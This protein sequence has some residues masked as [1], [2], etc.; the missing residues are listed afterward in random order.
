[1]VQ[2]KRQQVSHLGRKGQ[3][4][5]KVV[6]AGLAVST[7]MS[8]AA[9]AEPLTLSANQMDKVTASGFGFVDFDVFFDKFKNVNVFEN[10]NIQKLVN[11]NVTT[12][13]NLAMG[14]AD[15]NCSGGFFGCTAQ[16]LTASDVNFTG[17]TTGF[18]DATA[19]SQSVSATGSPADA[20]LFDLE[21]NG[22]GG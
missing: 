14:E 9:Q 11:S 21:V 20:I 5:N 18:W 10:V 19:A 7:A 13:G 12:F 22:N 4:M 1:M 3:V 17:G 15:S 2:R 16:A 6:F 8:F